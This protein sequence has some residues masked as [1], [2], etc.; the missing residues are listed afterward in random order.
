MLGVV[1]LF[2]LLHTRELKRFFEQLTAEKGE[3]KAQEKQKEM[4]HVLD[5]QDNSIF[6]VAREPVSHEEEHATKDQ[7]NTKAE[8][9]HS[10]APQ[11][12]FSN[13]KSAEHF[14]F[15]LNDT[16]ADRGARRQSEIQF[17]LHQFVPLYETPQTLFDMHSK[18]Q[19]E[20]FNN[21]RHQ[22]DESI[23]ETQILIQ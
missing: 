21:L 8:P 11:C 23:N 3:K 22:I 9:S 10:I 4:T 2:W 6:V 20:R 15:S 14:G 16:E 12:L 18:S 1:I 5:C 7:T 19:V 17:E 13:K